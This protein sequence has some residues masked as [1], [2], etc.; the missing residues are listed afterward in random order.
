MFSC[1]LMLARFV[2]VEGIKGSAGQK[3][4]TNDE[5]QEETIESHRT[6]VHFV[7]L[8]S[9]FSIFVVYIMDIIQSDMLFSEWRDMRD[10]IH[11]YADLYNC[12]HTVTRMH[13]I[14]FM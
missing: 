1:W 11:S 8:R 14:L 9:N 13:N 4:T 6:S 10:T 2:C 5:E 3:P 7:Q 12:R